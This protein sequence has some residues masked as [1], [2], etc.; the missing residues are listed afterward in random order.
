[1]QP[2][3]FLV[4][5]GRCGS[6]LLSTLLAHHPAVLSLSELFNA[7]APLGFFQD[8]IRGPDL[9]Y[10]LSAPRM[11]HQ[12]W[13][14]LLHSGL[15]LPEF[16]YPLAAV[17]CFRD[18]GIPP[19][20]AMTLPLLTEDPDRLHEELGVFVRALPEDRLSHQYQSI[21]AWLTGHLGRR[22]WCERS[23]ASLAYVDSL[24]RF[25]PGARFVHIARDG[26]ETALSASRFPPMRLGMLGGIFKEAVGKHPYGDG[27]SL[28]PESVPPALRPLLPESFDVGAFQRFPIPVERFGQAWSGLLLRGA[29]L[30]AELPEERL[31]NLRYES[32]LEAPERE[33]RRLLRFLDPSLEDEAWI[34]EAAQQVKPNPPRWRDLPEEERIRLESACAP[35][36]A[37]LERL[38]PRG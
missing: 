2:P 13:L 22:L 29:A 24:I 30:L 4:S 27:L 36:M 11:R 1:M 28:A 7:L 31:L 26:R 33:I 6:T 34:A 8:P 32:L 17:A 3:L 5:T 38:M 12:V 18:A 14:R 15:D 37:C 25:F 35:G 21:F 19:L 9:W 20:L 16:R 10:L 23:G